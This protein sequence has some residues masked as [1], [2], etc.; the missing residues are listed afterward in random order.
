MRL[1][2]QLPFALTT[3][4]HMPRKSATDSMPPSTIANAPNGVTLTTLENGL[5]IIVGEDHSAPVVS[6]QAWAM[7]GSI[8]EDKWLGAGLSHVLEHML[9]K[10]TET[11]KPGQIDQ[12]VHDA[13]GYMNAYTSFDR[14]VYYI[15]VPNDGATVSI[16][17]LCD[18]MQHASLPEDELA[19][20]MDVIRREI[21]MNQDDPGRRSGRRLFE[22]AYTKS[23]YRHTIIGYPDIFNG[24][25]REDI[26]GYYR[27]R[28]QPNNVFFVVVGD[29]RKDDVI[30][31]ISKAYENNRAKPMAPMVLPEEPRQAASRE[32]IEEAPVELGHLHFSWHVPDIRHPDIAVL[33]VLSTLL[34]SGRSS[35]L[36]REVREKQGVVH[37]ADAWTYS[38][39]L[40]GLFGM[41]AVVDADK[42]SEARESMLTEIEKLKSKAPT[43]AEVAKSIKQT[44]SHTYAARKTM[45]G[46]AQDLGSSWLATGDLNFSKR[47]LELVRKVTPA[48]ILRVA[49]TYL[50]EENRTLCALM[51]TGSVAAVVEVT[52]AATETEITRIVLEN[53][54]RLLVKEDHRLPFV[55][56]RVVF[57][58]GVLAEN[59]ANSGV[60]SL[61]TKLLLKGTKS[62]KAQQIA[63]EIESVGGHLDTYGGNNSIGVTAEVLNE[64]FMTGLELVADVIM[65][66]SFPTESLERERQVQLAA[67]KAQRDEL[68]PSCF[69][70]MRRALFGPQGYGLD[71][72]GTEASVGKLTVEDLK[73]LHAQLASPKNC[74]FAIYGDV[75][76]D[77]VEAAVKKIFSKWR[78]DTIPG[79]PYSDQYGKLAHRKRVIESRDKKQAVLVVGFPGTDLA[80]SDRYALELIQEA[81]SDLGSR[82]FTRIREQ[83]GLAYYVGA[84]NFLGLIPGY[85]AF[86][87][88][89]S[90]EQVTD[91]ER[92]L[93]EEARTLQRDGLSAEELKRAKAK[94]IGQ[95]KIARQELGG[96]AMATALDELYGLGYENHDKEDVRYEAVTLAQVKAV[97][98][99]YL[100]PEKCVVSVLRP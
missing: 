5:T 61:M 50:T 67:I 55:E 95:R 84:Q 33:D 40:P 100:N 82:L 70:L 28:Y 90:P 35:R 64:D 1:E 19:K 26:V 63:E 9:F 48:D 17:I 45:S 41:S 30:A 23:P 65:N 93:L 52:E 99:K 86:Y 58:G 92:E 71:N 69:K 7:T 66:P 15:D 97:A 96:Y 34:G 54:I 83:L 53:G 76:A 22:T 89:T 75:K 11:R 27:A 62:R 24:L 85:F 18:I 29:I 8:H 51:P 59:P 4:N 91:V 87:C 72:L 16:D 38:P 2:R 13:G 46:Q 57:R 74:V 47:F 56:F 10:G 20:E 32:R 49:Q 39:G 88:G 42:F 6:A 12:E 78:P 31:R 3:P 21:D 81:C 44:V 77:E 73:H 43:K 37:S 25:K 94:V 14:T 60:T 68:L 98:L 36:Y 79:A 80:G